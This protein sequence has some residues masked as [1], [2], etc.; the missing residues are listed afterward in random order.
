MAR[1]KRS[2]AIQ[3][4]RRRNAKR[5]GVRWLAENGADTAFRPNVFIIG[6]AHAAESGVCPH[7]SPTVLQDD[8]RLFVRI[9]VPHAAGIPMSALSLPAAPLSTHL[10]SARKF[11]SVGLWALALNMFLRLFTTFV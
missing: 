8:S 1:G 3:I 9:L 7:L 5:L 10:I 6:H 4:T 11:T 2:A